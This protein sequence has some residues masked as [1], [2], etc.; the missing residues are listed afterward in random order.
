MK[1]LNFRYKG[2]TC[3]G[4]VND[5]GE[6]TQFALQDGLIGYMRRGITPQKTS[7][8][9]NLSDVTLLAPYVPGK[10]IGVGRNYADHAKELKNELP[11][12]PLLFAKFPSSVIGTGEAITWR[13]AHTTQVDYEGELAVIIGKRA[14]HVSEE[15][16]LKHVFG[17]TIANDVSARDLQDSESQ[18]VRAKG[19]DTFCPI[20]PVIVSASAIEDPHKLN[21]VTKL[22]DKEMQNGNTSDMIFNIPYLIS[23]CS[24]SFV[25]EPGDMILTGTPSGVG[26]AQKPPRFLKDGDVVTVSIEGIGEISN[27]CKVIED[28][29]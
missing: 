19:L 11:T 14:S 10:I 18:W 3:I 1:L 22:N 6:I 9:V 25:L 17:Y 4:E 24:Q 27:P 7:E 16:A 23:Y 26:K 29:A 5:A 2:R 13:S 15:D 12:T 20:G 28:G 21:I 8:R